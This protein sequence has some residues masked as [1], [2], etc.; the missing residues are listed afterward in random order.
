M[1]QKKKKKNVKTEVF[2]FLIQKV[3]YMP[4]GAIHQRL[5]RRSGN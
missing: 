2:E 1:L 5:G 3:D 4:I